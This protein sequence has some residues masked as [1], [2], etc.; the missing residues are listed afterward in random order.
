MANLGDPHGIIDIA[1]N[2]TEWH[3]CLDQRIN[4]KS[5][6]WAVRAVYG[7]QRKMASGNLAQ[8]VL[9][10]ICPRLN[11][12]FTETSSSMLEILR[13]NI[14]INE[15]EMDRFLELMFRELKTSSEADLIGG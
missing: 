8:K 5:I 11:P 14:Y 2:L 7:I 15:K 1:E 13:M 10:A 9:D 3:R 12:A 4:P 6:F